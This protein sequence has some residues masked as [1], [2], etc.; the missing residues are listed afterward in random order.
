[1]VRGIENPVKVKLC[2]NHCQEILTGFDLGLLEESQIIFIISLV[3]VLKVVMEGK[4]AG[5]QEHVECQRLI[6]KLMEIC[7]STL[8]DNKK[9][10]LVTSITAIETQTGQN[11]EKVE[12]GFVK[13]LTDPAHAPKFTKS[14][15]KNVKKDLYFWPL[16][17]FFGN[18]FL[19]KLKAH[20]FKK[21][22]DFVAS[23]LKA[24][25]EDLHGESAGGQQIVSIMNFLDQSAD[26][27][28]PLMADSD[29]D[30]NQE[31][32]TILE[33]I[34]NCC[35]IILK[36]SRLNRA[37]AFGIMKDAM[38]ALIEFISQTKEQLLAQRKKDEYALLPSG[39]GTEFYHSEDLLL[40][41]QLETSTIYLLNLTVKLI[42]EVPGK[43]LEV[44]GD[45]LRIYLNFTEK[46]T[47]NGILRH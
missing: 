13:M 42:S 39:A 15:F 35:R 27:H 34:D 30:Q 40:L 37:N 32:N 19:E 26:D 31:S 28:K 10:V 29:V 8:A 16:D 43:K 25:Q 33:T 36:S 20:L 3:E 1:M 7:L 4:H 22:K 44:F 47:V 14:L 12:I 17:G 24:S 11:T 23:K 2:L 18:Q 41:Q 46:L 6:F 45:F 5:V 9:V 38:T 21:M